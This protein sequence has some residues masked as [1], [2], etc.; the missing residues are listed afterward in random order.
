MAELSIIL[1]NY[2]DKTHV[3]ECLSR[4][5]EEK[6]G[7]DLEIF[8]VDNASSDGSPDLI[9]ERFPEVFLIRSE[10]NLGFSRANNMGFQQSSGEFILFLNTDT[11][12]EPGTLESLLSWMRA[13]PNC[14]GAGPRLF[15]ERK[16]FQV[17]FGGS[18][19]FFS[20]M[21]DKLFFNS[22]WKRRI[23]RMQDTVDTDW[24]SAACLLV[25]RS[26]FESV[27][28]FD[29][30][31]FLYFEDIDLCL[32]IKQNGWLLTVLPDAQ[33]FHAGG[34]STSALSLRSRY[35]YRQ[36]QLYF[37]EKHNSRISRLLLRVFLRVNF[38]LLF[39]IGWVARKDDMDIRKDFFKL[40]V[41]DVE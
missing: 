28:G 18:R 2:N 22:L 35:F 21:M 14:G 13:H 29:G 26:A 34:A 4:I 3:G 41:K 37:Y 8:V 16:E 20:E 31:F 6:E 33:V 9:A 27:H 15:D 24:I 23:G 10:E 11:Q 17:S 7:L 5:Q 12:I 39:V 40:L 19:G 32:R 1:V 38:I 30:R 25:R 36:S